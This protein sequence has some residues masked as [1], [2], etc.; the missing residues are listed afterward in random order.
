MARP[1][2][3]DWH[4]LPLLIRSLFYGQHGPPYFCQIC[5]LEI[6]PGQKYRGNNNRHAHETCVQAL[7]RDAA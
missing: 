7:K 6:I 3:Y 2:K 5:H 4:E 1:T